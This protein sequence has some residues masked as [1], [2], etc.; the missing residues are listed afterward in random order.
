MS[1]LN[2]KNLI[3]CLTNMLFLRWLFPLFQRKGLKHWF[4]ALLNFKNGSIELWDSMKA[5]HHKA[6]CERSTLEMV[7]EFE[8]NIYIIYY[9][10]WTCFSILIDNYFCIIGNNGLAVERRDEISCWFKFQEMKIVFPP[11][12]PTQVNVHNYGLFL[13]KFMEKIFF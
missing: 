12:L 1:Y 7:S 9:L 8:I 4:M 2:K 3:D 5:S 6:T 11:G 13:L 10:I